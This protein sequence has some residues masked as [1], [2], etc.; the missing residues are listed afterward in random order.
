[1]I[2]DF[3]PS[4][5]KA[6]GTAGDRGSGDLLPSDLRPFVEQQ[7]RDGSS[8]LYAEATAFM[9]R[10]LLAEVMRTTGGNESKAAKILGMPRAA[11]RAKLRDLGISFSP[12]SATMLPDRDETDNLG[13]DR[14]DEGRE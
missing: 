10:W 1:V 3:L 14:L 13:G 9:D 4:E 8:N 6:A 12:E 2:A 5:L 11:L 7:L